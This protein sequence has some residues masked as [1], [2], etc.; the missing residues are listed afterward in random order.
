[1]APSL[2]LTK[3]MH[4]P[5]QPAYLQVVASNTAVMSN[6]ASNMVTANGTSNEIDWIVDAGVQRTDSLTSFSA[7]APTLYAY[8]ALTMQPIWSS[9]YQE[10]AMGGKYNSVAVARGDLFVGTHR[11]QAFGLTGDT[12]VDDAV[13]GTGANQ[14]TYTG[15]GWTHITGSS[16]MGTFDG[17]VSTD[18]VQGDFATLTFTGSQIRVYANE[19]SGYGTA[20]FTVD[21]GSLQTVV[22]SPANSSP[23]GQGA[24]DVLVRTP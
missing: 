10:V 20:T 14:F 7:G 8:N 2:I 1:V 4:S 16:T 17:T 11:I 15:T 24:G 13:T 6:P 3:I 18:N 12:I 21:G 23:N 5:G 9:A 19:K 22:L